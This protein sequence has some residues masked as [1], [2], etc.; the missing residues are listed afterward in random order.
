MPSLLNYRHLEEHEKWKFRTTYVQRKRRE[1]ERRETRISATKKLLNIVTFLMQ[2]YGM[3]TNNWTVSHVRVTVSFHFAHICIHKLRINN[4]EIS[5]LRWRRNGRLNVVTRIRIWWNAKMNMNWSWFFPHFFHLLLLI[6]IHQR[7]CRRS[8]FLGWGTYIY[9][10]ISSIWSA[11]FEFLADA[12]T[13]CWY[14]ET[15][16]QATN[17]STPS[18]IKSKRPPGDSVQLQLFSPTFP[19][20][21]RSCVTFFSFYSREQQVIGSRATAKCRAIAPIDWWLLQMYES[22]R[23]TYDCRT[24]HMVYNCPHNQQLSACPSRHISTIEWHTTFDCSKMTINPI[25]ENECEFAAC[26]RCIGQFGWPLGRV[27]SFA[28]SGRVMHILQGTRLISTIATQS[29]V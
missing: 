26:P 13:M 3:E 29:L 19:S 25:T 10:W 28:W 11:H 21:Y 22:T 18:N 15:E 2:S 8:T 9:S 4:P 14:D 27:S 16:R 6:S 12:W 5:S 24:T 7:R 23:H 17:L 20:I 1:R